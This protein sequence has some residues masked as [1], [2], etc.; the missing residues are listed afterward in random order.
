MSLNEYNFDVSVIV[1]VY[2]QWESIPELVNV[3]A[4]HPRLKKL[5]IVDNGTDVIP[6]ISVPSNVEITKCRTPG[7]YAARNKGIEKVDTDLVLFTD[8]DCLPDQNWLDV[9]IDVYQSSNKAT[10]LAGNVHIRSK[11][12]SPSTIELF[13]IASGLPQQ[14]YVSRGYAVTA[15]LAVP[16]EV[17]N[18]VGLFDATRFSGGDADFCQRALRAGFSLKYIPDA[19]VYH[20]ARKTWAEYATKVRRMKGGQIRAGRLSRR[21]K[22]FLITLLPPV[23]RF[24]RIAKNDKLKLGEKIRV[25]WFQ[26]RLW[27]VELTEMF[28]LLF[29][30]TPERR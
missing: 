10:L 21:L 5:I 23:W 29:G 27:G 13:D 17:F 3:L 15:N 24:W 28:A 25:V 6:N 18:E 22:Y 19:V 2:Q 1:P 12:L 4:L 8:A 7:S 11:S 30:K 20:P 16:R 14:H 26:C 9:M